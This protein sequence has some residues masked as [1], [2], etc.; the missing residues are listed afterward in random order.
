[1]AYCITNGWLN[2]V[3]DRIGFWRG[4][5]QAIITLSRATPRAD[6][7]GQTE[8]LAVQQQLTAGAVEQLPTCADD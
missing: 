4:M 8:A 6:D 5:E 3:L 7:L 2:P 1:M